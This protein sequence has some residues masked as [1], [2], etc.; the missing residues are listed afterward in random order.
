M[1]WRLAATGAALRA[2][3]IDLARARVIAEA[4]AALDDETA[5]AV[6]DRVLLRAGTQ[7]TAQLR[8]ALRRAVIAADPEGADRRREEAER[9]AK[10]TL[11]PDPDG[12]AS[13]AG[14]NLPGV[15]AAA[16]MARITA[17]ARALKASG[18]GGGID[19]LR[20]QVFVGLLLGTLPYIPPPD[21]PPPPAEPPS[22]D[23]PPPDD[24]QPADDPPRGGAGHGEAGHGEAGHGG[25]AELATGGQTCG[26]DD[27]DGPWLGDADDAGLGAR[28]PPAWPQVPAFLPPGPP[29]MSWPPP[30]GVGL[31]DLRVPW[32]SL[33]GLSSEPGYLTRLGPITAAQAGH[34]ASLAAQDPGVRWRVIV[35]DPTGRAQAVTRVGVGAERVGAEG[36]GAERT[37]GLI[38]QVTVTIGLECLTRPANPAD[39]P[40]ALSQ[41][42]AAAQG[43]TDAHLCAAATA[44]Y[45]PTR[46]LW[47]YI[48]ARDLTCRFQ[49]CRQPA[50]RCDLDHTVPFD[51]GGRTCSCNLG[52]V[53]RFH[54]QIKQHARWHL[55]QPAPGTFAWTTPTGR[56]YLVQPDSYAA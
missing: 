28:P 51:Q 33:T 49:T 22:P 29:A 27:R 48:T 31:L 39:L 8:A 7:T 12:T 46:Q 37:A 40:P 15:R 18:A 41:V 54:H 19:L 13:L 47:D 38:G 9:R 30:A 44:A 17:L 35:T 16:A 14:Y 3:T 11:Y 4:T 43:A 6:Q 20:A 52:A 25:D 53:C 55:D 50:T 23:S 36:V 26:F 2:G 24:S 32:A 56:T 5:Q 34:L 10:V 21:E 42:L 45:R 1:R